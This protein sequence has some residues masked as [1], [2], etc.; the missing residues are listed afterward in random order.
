VSAVEPG[1]SER[2]LRLDLREGKPQPITRDGVTTWAVSPD[3]STVAVGKAGGGI[4]L[5]AVAADGSAPRPL[6]GMTG[7][8]WP[9]GWVNDGLLIMRSG[10]LTTSEGVVRLVNIATGEQRTWTDILPQDRAGIMVLVSFRVTPDGR[11]RAYTW[12]RAL[13]DLYLAEGLV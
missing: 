8:E 13:S 6:G 3:G 10:D 7:D 12:H 1:R 4:D 9:V 2:L 5:Y 11:T